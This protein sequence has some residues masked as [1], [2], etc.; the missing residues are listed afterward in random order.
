MTS[1][2]EQFL[3]EQLSD[4][5]ELSSEFLAHYGVK[6]MKWGIRKDRHGRHRPTGEVLR[7]TRREKRA[8]RKE[9]KLARKQ[10]KRMGSRGTPKRLKRPTNQNGSIID[11]NQMSTAELNDFVNRIR[12]E[13]QLS[14]LMAV[15]KAPPSRVQA[16]LRDVPFDIAK[17]AVTDVGKD[18]LKIALKHVYNL[19][20]SDDFKIKPKKN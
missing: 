11:L 17:G 16:F 18:A 2:A 20:V 9:D 3:T 15:D 8:R 12:L 4:D 5:V 14:Q 1:K 19:T 6:G 7:E 10:E 13:Q